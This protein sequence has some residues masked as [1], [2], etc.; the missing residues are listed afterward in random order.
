MK[1]AC[2]RWGAVVAIVGVS[3]CGPKL[4]PL[5]PTERR[6][7]PVPVPVVVPV[8]PTRLTI[9]S[10]VPEHQYRLQ[11]VTE[12]ERDSAG[13]KETRRITSQA[14]VFVRMQRNTDGGFEAAGRIRGYS[15]TPS[16][17]TTPV[18]IDSL[19]FDALLNPTML[20]V[21]SQPLLANE[22]D[23]PET[24]ALTLVRDLL[25]RV[26]ASVSIGERWR[27]STIHIVCRSNVPMTVRTSSEYDVTQITQHSDGLHVI[28]RRISTTR[29]TGKTTSS[30]RALEVVGIGTGTLTA[31]V[32]VVSGAVTQV[33][34]NSSLVF[35]VTDS[36]APVNQRTQQVTQRV[37]YTAETVTR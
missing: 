17:S 16:L 13:K 30:W 26:P 37:T 21:V 27:D 35:T 32:A 3:A 8:L 18:V 1:T 15:I 4:V 33:S 7:E 2:V 9:P 34:G 31:D 25:V 14:N 24:G 22:C 36:G 23:R 10:V 5:P 19:R 6:P 20:R 11:S 29:M 12:L 28:V